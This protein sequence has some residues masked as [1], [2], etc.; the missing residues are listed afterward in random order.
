MCSTG[1]ESLADGGVD[2]ADA[3]DLA[4]REDLIARVAA[5]K[6][7]VLIEGTG[8]AGVGACFDMSNARVAELLEAK[9]VIITEGGIG[10][11]TVRLAA[12]PPGNVTVTTVRTTGDPDLG[13]SDGASLTPESSWRCS[14]A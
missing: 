8:H 5:G 7:V 4:G 13:V 10:T 3:A 2:S 11:F 14:G 6:N 12:Q 1:N 9:V